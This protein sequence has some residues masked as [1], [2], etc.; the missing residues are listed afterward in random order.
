MSLRIPLHTLAGFS[1]DEA[2]RKAQNA[3]NQ[4]NVELVM[5]QDNAGT[6]RIY[7]DSGPGKVFK[8]HGL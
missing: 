1:K 4:R 8:P 2:E 7:S 3:A 6:Y 5:E